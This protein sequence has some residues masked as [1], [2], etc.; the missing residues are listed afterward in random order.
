MRF[1]R[2][3][4]FLFPFLLFL[5]AFFVFALGAE[6]NPGISPSLNEFEGIKVRL[7]GIEKTQQDILAQKE[8]I[9]KE[10]NRVRV[11]VRHSGG[12]KHP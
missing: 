5:A 7:A 1:A 12:S 3:K 11:W 9:I 4:I 6:E 8:N 2:P 10:I